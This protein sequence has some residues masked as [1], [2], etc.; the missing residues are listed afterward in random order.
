MSAYSSTGAE[1]SVVQLSVTSWWR[2]SDLGL[3]CT[4]VTVGAV[5]S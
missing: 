3:T 4:V 1:G 2:A 5:T